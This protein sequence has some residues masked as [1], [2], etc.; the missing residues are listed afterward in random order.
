MKS[1]LSRRHV[2][3]I[4]LVLLV[5]LALYAYIAE[6][7]SWRPKTM[8]LDAL[9]GNIQFSPD[10]RTLIVEDQ[11]DEFREDLILCDVA[12]GTM[13]ARIPMAEYSC[14][15][16]NGK[17]M[18]AF[19]SSER[20]E[21]QEQRVK[22]FSVPDAKVA[23]SGPKNFIPVGVLADESTLI[24]LMVS[25]GIEDANVVNNAKVV[26]NAKLFRWNWRTDRAP[27]LHLRLP[28]A[29]QN[30]PWI[31]P[32]KATLTDGD[33]FWDLATGKLRFQ[34]RRDA[35][36][37]SR[38]FGVPH[39]NTASLIAY[40]GD[41][42]VKIW[43]YKT[44]KLQYSVAFDVTSGLMLSPDNS[45]LVGAIGRNGEIK[46][47]DIHSGQLLRQLEISTDNDFYRLAFSPDGRTLAAAP[48]GGEGIVKLWRVK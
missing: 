8:V 26:D 7:N 25:N 31:L 2:W 38:S 14:F 21:P 1:V 28:K 34:I 17:Y 23:M 35:D 45:T 43:N 29:P 9:V 5:P 24:G 46:L 33:H 10:G 39:A 12:S 42:K 36:I 20:F 41:E 22:I 11:N 27:Q 30:K 13:S 18:A 4:A 37:T 19:C 32:D 15:I 47:Q 44:G 40:L 3:K 48:D 16:E 6:R